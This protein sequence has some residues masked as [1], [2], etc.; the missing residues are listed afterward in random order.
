M[1]RTSTADLQLAREIEQFLP[2][3]RRLVSSLRRQMMVVGSEADDLT[4]AQ[5]LLET[6]AG[7]LTLRGNAH[8]GLDC[9]GSDPIADAER[10]WPNG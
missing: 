6:A 1:T 10:V 3:F 4:A 7:R 9:E 5:L 8:E 2:D